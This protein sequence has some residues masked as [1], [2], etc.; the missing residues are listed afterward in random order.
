[1]PMYEYACRACGHKFEKLVKTFNA[2]AP[3]CPACESP[4]TGRELSVFAVAGDGAKASS[5]PLPM[6]GGCRCGGPGPCGMN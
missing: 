2:A 5:T 1:M 6:G 3:A 4:E